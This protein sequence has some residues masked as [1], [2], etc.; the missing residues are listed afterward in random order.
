MTR[1]EIRNSVLAVLL[2]IAPEA[3]RQSLRDDV[4]LRE[5]LDLDSMDLLNFAIG[6]HKRFGVEIPEADYGRLTTIKGC[7]DFILAKDASVATAT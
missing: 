2:Q 6:I 5:Q 1:D 3:D 7:I 4:E